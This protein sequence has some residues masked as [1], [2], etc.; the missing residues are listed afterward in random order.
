MGADLIVA[1][2]E[3]TVSQDEAI[4]RASKL[5]N[6]DLVGLIKTLDEWGVGPWAGIESELPTKDEALEYLRDQIEVVYSYMDRRDCVP[7][8][9]DGKVYAL[10]GGMSW[11][12][13][14]TDAYDAF[15][16]CS[17]LSLT[18]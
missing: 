13:T 2:C 1:I 16:V 18:E 15:S 3:M 6:D 9:I 17:S 10:T 4:E 11:G 7:L 14:P 8:N 5:V 12:D